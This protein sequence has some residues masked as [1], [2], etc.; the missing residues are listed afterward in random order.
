MFSSLSVKWD[1]YGITSL[2]DRQNGKGDEGIGSS[3]GCQLCVGK[4]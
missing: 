3:G 2:R 4:F 1:S